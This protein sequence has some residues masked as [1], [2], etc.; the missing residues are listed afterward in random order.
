M[1]LNLAAQTV[2]SKKLQVYIEPM[3]LNYTRAVRCIHVPI[4]MAVSVSD[5]RLVGSIHHL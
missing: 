4:D 3:P 2:L 5:V 1:H